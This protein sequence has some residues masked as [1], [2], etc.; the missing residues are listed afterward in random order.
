M[1]QLDRPPIER[2]PDILAA[3]STALDGPPRHRLQELGERLRGGR[4]QLAVLGQF[5]RG[6]STFINALIGAPLL[7]VAVL[8]LTAVPIFVAW[9]PTARAKVCFANGRPAEELSSQDPEA[10]RDFLFRFTSEEANPANR[11]AVDRVELFYPASLL[12]DEVVLIDT[13]GIGST[14]RHNT[15]AALRVLPECDAALFVVSVDPPI[16]EAELAYLRDVRAAISTL[17]YVLNKIDYVPDAERK[18]VSDFLRRVLRENGLWNSEATVFEISASRGLDAKMSADPASLET[19]GLPAVE[20]YLTQ[21]LAGRKVQLLQQAIRHKALRIA[22]TALEEIRF[23]I[24]THEMP[25]EDLAARGD[26]FRQA[27]ASIDRQR[28]TNPD[29]ID[30]ERRRL[31]AELEQRIAQLRRDTRVHLESECLAPGAEPDAAQL[32]AALETVFETACHQL[33][34]QFQHVLAQALDDQ[35]RRI[36]ESIEEVRRIAGTIFDVSFET[37][38]EIETIVI[39][40]EPYWVT[41]KLETGLLEAPAAL[42]ERLLPASVRAA[43]QRT[44][45]MHELDELILRNAENLRWALM[46]GIEETFRRASPAFDAQLDAAI[47]AIDDIVDQAFKRKSDQSDA[48]AGEISQLEQMHRRVSELLTQLLVLSDVDKE[49]G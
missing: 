7:P 42:V 15:E 5:K 9:G 22:Q 6:K 1:P 25:I 23:R 45:A 24:R 44:R 20:A 4:F 3:L 18:R 32:S 49:Q 41:S 38:P 31:K 33:T 14:H 21:T 46:R 2:L 26:A 19:S 27:L 37:E 28:K 47:H 34:A 17:V 40:E 10:V 36:G 30:G 12:A 8:P 43:R 16:T 11:L 39:A 48:V 35:R 13:P 29:L